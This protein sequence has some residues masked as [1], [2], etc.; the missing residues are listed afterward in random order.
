MASG[1]KPLIAPMLTKFYDTKESHQG[2]NE[3]TLNMLDCFKDYK[4]CIHISYHILDFVP[5]KLTRFTEEQP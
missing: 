1:N 3:L 2:V 5:Q 4:I